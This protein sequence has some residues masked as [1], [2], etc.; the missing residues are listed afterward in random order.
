MTKGTIIFIVI[1]A[2]I[3]V[4][5][6]IISIVF[7]I[8]NK[9]KKKYNSALLELEREKNNI[10]SSSLLTEL[11]KIDSLSNNKKLKEKIDN[12]NK[13]FDK[14][15]NKS[16]PLITDEILEIENKIELKHYKEVNDML[17]KTELNIYYIKT[18]ANNLLENIREITLSEERNREAIT[19]LKSIYRN[20]VTKYN[21][22]KE[23]YKEIS[24]VIELQFENIDKLFSA[25][26]R[27][28]EEKEFEEIGKIVKALD[29][30]IKNIEII[31]DESPTVLF[32]NKIVLPKKIND[33]KRIYEKMEKDGYFLGYMNFKYN[34]EEAEKKLNDIY[35]RLK[36]LDIEDS[37][38]ELKTMLDYFESL[39][40]DFDKEK[41]CKKSYDSNIK[42]ISDKI[43][44]LNKIVKNVYVEL[45][46]LKSTYNLSQ[47]ELNLI[48]QINASLVM[49]KDEFKLL[50]D[51]T[52]LKIESF[53]KISKEL[54]MLKVKLSKIEDDLE[55]TIKGL[56]SLKE[57]EV[58][59]RDQ[60]I[61]IRSILKDARKKIRDYKLPI[62][63]KNYFVELKEAEYSVK[64]IAEELAK[65]PI[66][67]K[68][69]NTRVDTARDLALKL[70]H[71]SNELVKAAAMAELAIV[72]GNRYRSSY[73]DV[74]LGLINSEKAFNKGDYRKSLELV[75]TA[76]NIVEPGIHKR[77]LE[78]YQN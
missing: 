66:N 34:L 39:F 21:K 69:L 27:C 59:A 8:K 65:K 20:A 67:I 36:T 15:K 64:L 45:E 22:N 72:Y 60:L 50:S 40:L 29:D 18:E 24:G 33:L 2:V 19:K 37:V 26:E 10:I 42:E 58:R 73:K 35:D 3:I 75:L 25:F 41:L 31:I 46:T 13:T 74:E 9:T 38:F 32:M 12:W 54:E 63:P 5:S 61:E 28:I 68:A 56:S 43:T 7:F 52:R 71:T 62:I 6:L 23:D 17:A 76:L 57:D 51:R 1:T 30:L 14:L 78:S 53:S 16:L 77:L 49:V 47:E 55:T 11:G 70:Y 48:D 44:N 4:V